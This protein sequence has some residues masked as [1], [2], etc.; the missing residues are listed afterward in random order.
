MENHN[1]SVLKQ[2]GVSRPRVLLVYPTPIKPDAFFGFVLPPLGLERIGARLESFADVRILDLRFESP[3]W[4]NIAR[5]FAP[6]FIG[7]NVKT[8]M[9]ASL[10][11]FTA[12]RLRAAF[13]KTRIILGGLHASSVP[14]EALQHAD[15]VVIGEGEETFAEIVQGR[16]LESIQ[17][18]C[19]LDPQGVP[20]RTSPRPLRENL[21]ELPPPARHLRPAR[22]K[23]SAAG[24]IPMDLLETSRG[25]D[26][27]CPFCSPASLHR[28]RWRAHSPEYVLE[29]V[30]RIAARGAK[31]VMLTDDHFS[32]D[33]DRA[34]RISELIVAAK[35]RIAFFCFLRPFL[36][37]MDV[38]RAMVEAGFVMLSYGAESP[39]PE[40]LK[41]YGKGFSDPDQFVAGVN[42]EWHEAGARYIGNSFVF[43]DPFESA[44]DLERLGD[45]ARDLDPTYIEPL[46][47]QP[48][49]GTRYREELERR[50]LLL[51]RPWDAFTEGRLL[52]R[53]PEIDE[54]G[55]LTKRVRMW[56]RF[57]S[58]RK[59][60]GAF[61]VPLYF[62][63]TI[64]I[65]VATTLRYMKACDYCTFGCILEDKF[66]LH[67]KRSM[68]R[69]Y[70]TEH[71][72]SFS[73]HE[74]DMTPFTDAFTDMIGFSK[75]KRWLGTRSFSLEI[76]DG[77]TLVTRVLAEFSGGCLGRLRVGLDL[78]TADYTIRMRLDDAIELIC[79]R[80][81]AKFA[82]LIRTFFF[83]LSSIL[84]K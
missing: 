16:P 35:I 29:E 4:M 45:Y 1:E 73:P 22:Y 2:A 7:V 11:Y 53:H 51:D 67:R 68:L 12:D 78:P 3:D 54:A 18:L 15:L 38:K 23:Y 8:T 41:R 63:E 24:L 9:Y 75:V 81:P 62:H 37:R 58:P 34:K 48:F 65:P 56:L 44:E 84:F 69:E 50:G 28:G 26:R 79:G 32:G 20:Q 74:R 27:Y 59:V 46:Y 10:S 49:P 6:D 47:S 40:Q 42:R 36:G 5:A 80:E 19:F 77:K 43:G 33:L 57:F 72:N 13:P 25:C 17:G 39:N 31:Y 83:H 70:L 66:Y 52:V 61:R 76:L 64:G 30:K 82:A 71:I 55:L 60:A 14:E 21:D